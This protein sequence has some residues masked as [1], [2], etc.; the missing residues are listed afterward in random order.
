MYHVENILLLLRTEV[1]ELMFLITV[2]SS[3]LQKKKKQQQSR[4]V[5]MTHQNPRLGGWWVGGLVF[6]C[7]FWFNPS[8]NTNTQS[9]KKTGL[10]GRIV[11]EYATADSP[12]FYPKSQK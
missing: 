11:R 3:F 9:S 7:C 1:I 12:L 8:T 4:V 10:R 5:A 6:P 2:P